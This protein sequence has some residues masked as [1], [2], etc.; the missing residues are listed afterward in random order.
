MNVAA[1][2]TPVTVWAPAA[3]FPEDRARAVH[4]AA[5]TDNGRLEN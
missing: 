3:G 4:I 5:L 2:L 1:V